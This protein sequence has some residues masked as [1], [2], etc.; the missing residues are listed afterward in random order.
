MAGKLTKT[1]QV[2]REYCQKHPTVSNRMLARML[3]RDHPLLFS[4][5]EH[6]RTTIRHKRGANGQP[7][8]DRSLRAGTLVERL[9][10]PKSDPPKYE[11]YRLPEAVKR[12]LLISDLHIP[13]H[14]EG[15]VALALDFGV[16]AKCDGVIIL[17]DLLDCYQISDF[18][19]Q[20][21]K[22]TLVQEIE[23]ADAFFDALALALKPKSIVWKCGNHEARL[24]GYQA[25]KSPELWGLAQS[26][27]TF[28][29]FLNL[30]QRGITW[31]NSQ[32]P[33][34]HH[35]LTLIHGHEWGAGRTSPV[36]PARGAFT[37]GVSCMVV[38]HE[39]RTSS[40]PEPDVRGTLFSN[41][42]LGCLCNLHP[43]YRPLNKWNHGFAILHAG[44]SWHIE[45][46]SI[47]NGEVV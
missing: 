38:G 47:V 16:R 27:M 30:K 8:R 15:A 7:N 12:W 5:V 2:A 17:G 4:D 3:Y 46:H 34:Y 26:F 31:V 23:L 13:Y 20:P 37:R 41:W 28:E 11:P 21:D 18:N 35:H 45:N 6:A 14:D 39:H 33:I 42:S 24:E 22:K 19:R 32:S 10:I 25:K 36:N 43:D 1:G 9:G 44:S 40:H 29:Q